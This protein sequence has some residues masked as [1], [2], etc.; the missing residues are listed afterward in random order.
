MARVSK[1]NGESVMRSL[2]EE[3]EHIA[4]RQHRARAAAVEHDDR[5]RPFEYGD[6]LRH[7]LTNA[8]G[9]QRR[10]HVVADTAVEHAAF[11][12]HAVHQLELAYRAFDLLRLERRL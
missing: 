11:V 6:D 1:E 10:A 12:E 8:D 4:A 9:R 7:R 2:V 5:G 3:C